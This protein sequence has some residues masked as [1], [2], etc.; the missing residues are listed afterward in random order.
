MVMRYLGSMVN[1][2]ASCLGLIT[3]I[4]CVVTDRG[5]FTVPIVIGV[6]VVAAVVARF[7]LP[8]RPEPEEPPK[9]RPRRAAT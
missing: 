4:M 7:V 2:V 1:V 9:S 8:Q 5:W 6:Y 3:L